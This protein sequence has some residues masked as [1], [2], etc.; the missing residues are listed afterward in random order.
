MTASEIIGAVILILL[1]IYFIACCICANNT[2]DPI[3]KLIPPIKEYEPTPIMFLPPEE[4]PIIKPI[5]KE[6]LLHSKCPN[7]GARMTSNT[8][9]YCDMTFYPEPYK[10]SDLINNTSHGYMRITQE[11]IFIEPY[12]ITKAIEDK[13]ENRFEPTILRM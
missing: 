7:C 2:E 8:C 6:P 10:P 9:E 4:E 3:E 12:D 13:I 11:G 5:K 1:I